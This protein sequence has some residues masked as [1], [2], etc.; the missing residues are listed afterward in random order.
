MYSNK[1]P[2]SL[3]NGDVSTSKRGKAPKPCVAKKKEKKRARRWQCEG[4]KHSQKSND[5]GNNVAV[6][7]VMEE[8]RNNEKKLKITIHLAI[9]SHPGGRAVVAISLG[10][11]KVAGCET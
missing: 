7:C 2:K 9:V 5:T 6:I 1:K 10:K 3:I 4:D 8:I 11:R